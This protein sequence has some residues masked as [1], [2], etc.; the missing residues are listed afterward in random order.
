LGVVAVTV[1]VDAICGDHHHQ[2]HYLVS[3][4]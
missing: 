3:G 1:V 4:I 2:R